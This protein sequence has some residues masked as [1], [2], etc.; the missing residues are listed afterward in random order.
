MEQAFQ[1]VEEVVGPSSSVVAGPLASAQ[2]V[3][4]AL[5]KAQEEHHQVETGQ[6]LVAASLGTPFVVVLGQ[7]KL[8]L[9]LE[10][11]SQEQVGTSL[12]VQ[13]AVA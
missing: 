4:A 10:G 1:A 5:D 8:S 9:A 12:V 2:T 13:T 11:E 6:A 7:G 3:G